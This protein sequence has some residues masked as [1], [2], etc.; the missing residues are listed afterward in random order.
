MSVIGQI[1]HA[2]HVLH[3]NAATADGVRGDR[4]NTR[5]SKAGLDGR[6]GVTPRRT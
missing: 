3:A 1:R 5:V 6:F 4:R 2:L